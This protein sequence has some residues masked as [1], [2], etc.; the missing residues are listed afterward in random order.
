MRASKCVQ[1]AGRLFADLL[2]DGCFAG[3]GEAI[4]LDARAI[5]GSYAHRDGHHSFFVAATSA[6]GGLR[7]ARIASATGRRSQYV[8]TLIAAVMTVWCV[9]LGVWEL[10]H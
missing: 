7:N 5:G 2:R 1:Q 10:S 8:G 4:S 3:D 9:Y 6:L